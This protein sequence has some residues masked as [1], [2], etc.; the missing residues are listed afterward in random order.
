[1]LDEVTQSA[2]GL[3]VKRLSPDAQIPLDPF[4][5]RLSNSKTLTLTVPV[6]KGA[7]LMHLEPGFVARNKAQVASSIRSVP[8][9]SRVLKEFVA[10]VAATR[11][12]S[13]VSLR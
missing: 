11:P 13:H 6:L 4:M 5:V 9:G 2:H 7:V 1:M 8:R 3:N 10:M 12:V